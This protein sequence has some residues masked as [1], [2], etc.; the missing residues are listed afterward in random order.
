MRRSAEIFGLPIFSIADGRE[1]GHVTDV[2]FDAEKRRVFL[3]KVAPVD[4]D[5]RISV[6]PFSLIESI[7]DDAIMVQDAKLLFNAGQREEVQRLLH[8]NI[9]GKGTRALNRRG[10]FIGVVTEVIFD[11]ETGRI[12]SFEV[13]RTD[14]QDVFK[15]PSDSILSFSKEILIFEEGASGARPAAAERP[16][17]LPEAEERRKEPLFSDEDIS[18]GGAFEEEPSRE[19]EPEPETEVPSGET[20][21]SKDLNEIFEEHQAT[22]ILG[23]KTS[24]EL[25]DDEG[26]EIVAAGETVTEEVI[27]KAKAAGKFIPLL[28]NIDLK[29]K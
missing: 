9:R 15:I 4:G 1:V 13:S 23:K 3:F 27:D 7:G 28:M 18:A 2:V 26:N 20:E 16:V 10:K 19:A 17:W 25:V 11:E 21:A 24:Q 8:Q 12:D 22:L 29:S 14:S 5:A 6:L